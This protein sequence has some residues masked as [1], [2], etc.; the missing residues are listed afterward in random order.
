MKG[1]QNEDCPMEEEDFKFEIPL[2]A[3]ASR[4]G[5]TNLTENTGDREMME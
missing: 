2:P 4:H 1:S 5:Y 3:L